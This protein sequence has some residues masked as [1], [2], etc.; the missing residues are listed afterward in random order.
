MILCYIYLTKSVSKSYP[1]S[2]CK[3]LALRIAIVNYKN[4]FSFT[5]VFALGRIKNCYATIGAQ[6]STKLPNI[7]RAFTNR[8]D[9]RLAVRKN[10]APR[11][12]LT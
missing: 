12:T 7:L 11:P 1:K 5:Y 10:I 6:K 9:F 3:H 4:Y 2:Y 8:L